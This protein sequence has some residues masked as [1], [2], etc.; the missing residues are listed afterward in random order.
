MTNGVA[1]GPG[2]AV[3]VGIGVV[4][5]LS[6]VPVLTVGLMGVRVVTEASL[7]HWT[8]T[9]SVAISAKTPPL[10]FAG[11]ARL[12]RRE[13]NCAPGAVGGGGGLA[14]YMIDKA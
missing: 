7:E 10:R 1:V 9:N 6:G 12:P 3:G 13:W 2:V 14:E 4:A 8:R 11:K 5:R